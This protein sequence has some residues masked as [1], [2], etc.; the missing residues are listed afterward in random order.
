MCG[1]VGYVG[2]REA[3]PILVEGLR[4]LEY[5]GYDSAGV[6]TLTGSHLHLRK[7]AGR[8]ADLAAHLADQP[9]P[10]PPASA[11][12]AGPRTAP[13]PTATPTRTS[14]ATAPSPSSTTASSRTTP[15]SS[16]SSQ[17]DGVVFHSDTDTEVIAH[18]IAR[19]LDGDLVDAVP[20]GAAAAQGHLRPG[21]RQPARSRTSSSAP[22]SAA[23]W[24]S[25]SATASTSSPATRRALAGYADKVVYLD[26]HQ[27]CVL[28]PDDWHILDREPRAGR[29]RASTTLDW[30][31][32]RRRHGR[33]RALHA[34]GDLRAARGAGERPARPARRRRR[35]APTSAA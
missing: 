25:A 27:L 32:E 31:A 18:L 22:A 24:S 19:H 2:Q 15:P 34:Q 23:R 5:R 10:G 35:H 21:R 7:R 29:R 8:I 28:T 30:R 3:E 20:H 17:A 16:A 1:I 13:P 33:L 11:T 26:D 12:P 4:R 9:A 14:A 6:A